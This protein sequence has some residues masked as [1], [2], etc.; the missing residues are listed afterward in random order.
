MGIEINCVL[1]LIFNWILRY[2]SKHYIQNCIKELLNM[3]GAIYL[4]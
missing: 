3:G 1:E 4:L 2:F